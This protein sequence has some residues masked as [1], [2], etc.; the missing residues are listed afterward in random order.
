MADKDDDKEKK[1]GL[2]DEPTRY[3]YGSNTSGGM[4]G[5]EETAKAIYHS[6]TAPAPSAD[7]YRFKK[8][9]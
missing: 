7:K 4:A 9:S 5:I 6:L 3:R 1:K 2:L 8:G